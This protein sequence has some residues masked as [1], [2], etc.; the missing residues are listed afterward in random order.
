MTVATNRE[1]REARR[2][3][4][5][6]SRLQSE[7]EQLKATKSAIDQVRKAQIARA[8]IVQQGANTGTSGSSA[9]AGATGAVQ[10]QVGGNIAFAQSVF[11]LNQQASAQLRRAAAREERSGAIAATNSTISSAG[12]M[13]GGGS[14]G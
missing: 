11:D 1:N 12:G 7:A 6:A 3:R 9:V 5:E 2:S 8:Q 4:Q 10:S 13:F 14:G